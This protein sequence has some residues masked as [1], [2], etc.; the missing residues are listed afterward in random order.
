MISAVGTTKI[1]DFFFTFFIF[2]TLENN[3]TFL[4][5]KSVKLLHHTIFE[6]LL[7]SYKN[8]LVKRVSK[9]LYTILQN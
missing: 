9:S 5:F 1:A 4:F 8:F 3:G 6:E 2:G 7:K